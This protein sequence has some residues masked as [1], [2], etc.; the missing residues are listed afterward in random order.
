[1]KA[2]NYDFDFFIYHI[3]P[4]MI[5]VLGLIGNLT[6]ILILTKHKSLDQIGPVD[7]YRQLFL[8]DSISLALILINNYLKTGFSF[9]FSLLNVFTCKVYKF[10]A[11]LVSSF[12]SFILL[13]ILVERFLALKH[14]VENNFLRK[15]K[16]QM[17]YF[18]AITLINIVFLLPTLFYHSIQTKVLNTNVTVKICDLVDDSKTVV[19]S[20]LFISRTF[21]P[22]VLIVLFTILL[23]YTIIKSKSRLSTF[24]SDRENLI[25]KKDVNLSITA[26][27]INFLI[28]F[29]NIPIIVAYSYNQIAHPER[30]F[31]IFSYFFYCIYGIKFYFF[32]IFNS[33]FRKEFLNLILLKRNEEI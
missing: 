16:C 24:Y 25:F 13:Y 31:V 12:S 30:T 17:A 28:I 9:S 22:F 8:T 2:I 23:I 5:L 19:K 7:S 3:V 33:L 29:C 27:L 15:K 4:I 6:G 20:F 18:V 10:S 14:P 11:S 1:M 32:I 21:I 26:V